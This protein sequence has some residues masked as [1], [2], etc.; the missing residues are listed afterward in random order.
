M[1]NLKIYFLFIYLVSDGFSSDDDNTALASYVDNN[2]EA[3]ISETETSHQSTPK[4]PS[5]RKKSKYIRPKKVAKEK[6]PKTEKSTTPRSSRSLPKSSVICFICGKSTIRLSEHL[7]L[8]TTG[9][10]E[11]FQCDICSKHLKTRATLTTHIKLVHQKKRI[12]CTAPGCEMLFWNTTGLRL[13]QNKVHFDSSDLLQCNLCKAS[14]AHSD[15]LTSHLKYHEYMQRKTGGKQ[16]YFKSS[17]NCSACDHVYFTEH[18]YKA[19]HEAHAGKYECKFCGEVFKQSS[20]VAVHR[21]Y[22]HKTVLRNIPK[23]YFCDLCEYTTT[24]DFNLKRHQK[25]MHQKVKG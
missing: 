22:V 8:H 17:L 14:F 3:K 21:K 5:K 9:D 23:T 24:H 2:V 15:T 13:H 10:E 16:Q 7:K 4:V 11:K 6:K 18:Q 1:Q 20:T 25:I 19:H 12:P